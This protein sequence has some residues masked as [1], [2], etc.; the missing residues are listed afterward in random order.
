VRGH[1]RLIASALRPAA[2]DPTCSTKVPFVL[3]ERIESHERFVVGGLIRLRRCA[4]EPSYLQA[5]FPT[6]V[7]SGSTQWGRSGS[8]EANEGIGDVIT[9][10]RDEMLL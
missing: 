5:P 1:P 9:L 10:V 4:A 6:H 2:L 7:V 8:L 3:T